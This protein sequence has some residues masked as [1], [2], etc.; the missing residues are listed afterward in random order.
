MY[1]KVKESLLFA[2]VPTSNRYLIIL[3]WNGQFSFF[4]LA[5]EKR[6]KNLYLDLSPWADKRKSATL[7]TGIELDIVVGLPASLT[8]FREWSAVVQSW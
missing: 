7:M 1:R 3:T 4:S 8:D 6:G 5:G 2:V